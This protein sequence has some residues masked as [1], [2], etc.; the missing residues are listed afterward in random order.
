MRE[1]CNAL[2]VGYRR[3]AQLHMLTRPDT[4]G[5]ASLCCQPT[6]GCFLAED[7]H[8]LPR[9]FQAHAEKMQ[10]LRPIR[11]DLRRS[12]EMHRWLA[13]G[14]A[15]AGVALAA[16]YLLVLWPSAS[17][18]TYPAGAIVI[19][20]LTVFVSASLG[21]ACAVIAHNLDQRIY[22]GSDIEHFLGVEPLAELPDFAEVSSASAQ[23]HLAALARGI[24]EVCRE[25]SVRRCVFTGTGLG[26]GVS[27]VAARTRETLKATGR[28]VMMVDAAWATPGAG[29]DIAGAADEGGSRSDSL[30][31]TDTAPLAES[32]DTEFL[33][34]FADCVIVIVESGVTTRAQ[35]RATANCLQRLNAAAVGFVVNRVRPA[36]SGSAYRKWQKARASLA[37]GQNAGARKQFTE[38]VQRAL[39]DS[40]QRTHP[41]VPPAAKPLP[42]N[43]LKRPIPKP[44]TAL[45]V[46]K[47]P[48][49]QNRWTAEGIPPWLSEAL[50]QLE[51]EAPKLEPEAERAA[52]P[53]QPSNWAAELPK[54]GGSGVH[55][56][57]EEEVT[58]DGR[59]NGNASQINGGEAMLFEMNW[60]EPRTGSQA[61]PQPGGATDAAVSGAAEG[62]KPSRLDGL[63]G[64]VTVANLRELNH[65]KHAEGIKRAKGEAIEATA[66][67]LPAPAFDTPDEAPGRLS[68]L[69]GM[70]T[71]TD[72]K[73]L[74]QARQPL[75]PAREADAQAA[76]TASQ[77]RP[78]VGD[79]PKQSPKSAQRAISH[80]IQ[81]EASAA[82][83]K[84]DEAKPTEGEVPSKPPVSA[85][86]ERNASYDEV[87]ILPSKRGQ[88]RRKTR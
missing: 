88:Y 73:E 29:L 13:L 56:A 17:A 5:W 38:A 36:Q 71:P 45:T 26:A 2:F 60:L 65:E 87:Q 55:G 81:E 80:P 49:Q 74:S 48:E 25:G 34:R 8:E 59:A 75:T 76:G 85:G 10:E 24:G 68:S 47:R 62:R 18:S 22:I 69:R 33:T 16:I 4:E 43:A 70:V 27:T 63:R 58:T 77:E 79:G 40:P 42:A 28:A 6:A 30:I 78:Q 86:R 50:A 51:A 84:A 20:A 12:L 39:A 64:M 1:A 32:P 61:T 7:M 14:I 23:E 11:V 72:L 82:T 54:Q 53:L 66:S 67:E 44:T 83:K 52:D 31:L 41:A 9:W 19:A 46:V 57:A 37:A 35:L 15:L 3:G 21:A